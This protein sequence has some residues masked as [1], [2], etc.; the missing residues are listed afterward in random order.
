MIGLIQNE[1]LYEYDIR[2]LILA[3]CIGEKIELS[4]EEADNS[5]YDFICR[6]FYKEEETILK[7]TS[8]ETVLSERTKGDY[9]DK[10]IFKN[11]LKAALYRL[12]SRC[13]HRE[14]PWGT[15][16]GIRPTKL[17]FEDCASGKSRKEMEAKLR[18]DYLVSSEKAQLCVTVGLKETELLKDITYSNGYSLYVGIPFC[19]STC[20]YC[21]FTSYPISAYKEYVDQYLDALLREIHYVGEQYKNRQM[22]SLYVG[23]GTPTTL[24]P[25]QLDRLFGE[26]RQCFDF[27]RIREITVE[28]GRPDSISGEKLAVLSENGVTRISIN[29]QTMNNDTLKRIGRKHTAEDVAD[30]F[31]AARKMGFDNINMDTICGLPG[32]GI[33]ELETTFAALKQLRPD[34]IT[35]HAL[36]I[37][38]SAPLNQ[39]KDQYSFG[40]DEFMIQYAQDACFDMG[41]E[42]YYMYRQKN[43]PG[44]FENT[45]FSLEEK[46]CL[47]NI[48]IME[49]LHDIVAVGA[50][51]SSKILGP[52]K[53][54]QRV[55]NLKDVRQYTERIGE[56]ILRKDKLLKSLR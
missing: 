11:R 31:E 44:N 35:V 19:P 15:L 4:S 16:N 18:R 45:G 14:L 8:G 51:A 37:K 39:M 42:P 20:L 17:I 24:S 47:Y 32:E 52:E 10:K 22:V 56:M 36:A 2:S 25:K 1:T 21:S 5:I 13:L 49:E 12:L 38:R 53:D 33:K 30:S 34:S 40:A 26:L 48:L 3:F 27:G 55:E 43:I 54:I 7:L 50:G 23:G 41:M 29:P 9:R 28:A 46:E 6:V